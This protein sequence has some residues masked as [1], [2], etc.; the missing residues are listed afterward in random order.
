MVQQHLEDRHQ[1]YVDLAAAFRLAAYYGLHEAIANHFSVA[2]NDSGKRFIIQPV[3]MHFSEIKSSDL[4][5]LN[6]DDQN[7]LQSERAPDPTGWFIHAHLHQKLPQAK[8]IMHIHAP[9][10]LALCCL[11]NFEFLMLDQ[12]AC[13]FHNRVAY[14]YEYRGMALED[15][16]GDRLAKLI[17]SDKNI[18]MMAN[19][20]IIAIG[21]NIA[22]TFN[23]LYYF[24]RACHVQW[25]AM[26]S[27]Q[28]LNEIPEAVAQKTAAEWH[29]YPTQKPFYELHFEAQKR[30]LNR[31]GSDYL[32]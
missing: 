31:L 9:W 14:D 11:K 24:E 19:H 3:G 2:V 30:M 8:C 1:L 10:S 6:V 5:E 20:G 27:N 16:E 13:L 21:R 32:N 28:L 22:E 18:L 25:L 12:N 26:Q 15:S 17:G 7:S 29:D 4:I 23:Y